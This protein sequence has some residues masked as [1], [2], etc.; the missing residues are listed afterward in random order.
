MEEK[1]WIIM[2]EIFVDIETN[3]KSIAEDLKLNAEGIS[4]DQLKRIFFNEVAPYCAPNMMAVIPPI[5][6]GFAPESLIKGIKENNEKYKNSIYSR[7][8]SET[9]KLL[10]KAYI[11]EEWENLEKYL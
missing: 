6:T 7:I 3:Y 5:W 2:S 1:I 8:K 4:N 9:F 11:N 10:N